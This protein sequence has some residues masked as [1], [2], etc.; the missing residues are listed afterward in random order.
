MDGTAAEG[1]ASS[2]EVFRLVE[3]S[4]RCYMRDCIYTTYTHQYTLGVLGGGRIQG[5]FECLSNKNRPEC[6]RRGVKCV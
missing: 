4:W 3:D 2:A 1:M 5:G 6:V